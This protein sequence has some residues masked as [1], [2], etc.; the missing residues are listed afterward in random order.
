MIQIAPFY[1]SLIAYSLGIRFR[2]KLVLTAKIYQP[3]LFSSFKNQFASKIHFR[4]K[5]RNLTRQKARTEP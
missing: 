5:L 1:R 4:K 3:K 2:S